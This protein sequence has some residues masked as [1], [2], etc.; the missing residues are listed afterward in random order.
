MKSYK[1][2]FLISSPSYSK[3]ASL[4]YTQKAWTKGGGGREVKD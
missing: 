2:N 1:E 4:T 3:L